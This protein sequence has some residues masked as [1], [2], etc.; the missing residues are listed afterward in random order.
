M[1]KDSQTYTHSLTHT[2]LTEQVMFFPLQKF[3]KGEKSEGVSSGV[4][5]NHNRSS[6][7]TIRHNNNEMK[8]GTVNLSAVAVST[9]EVLN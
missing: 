1:A 4:S 2:C 3:R 8:S 6:S 5:V 7:S 9:S